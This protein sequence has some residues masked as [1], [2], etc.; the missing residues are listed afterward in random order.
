MCFSTHGAPAEMRTCSKCAG[1]FPLDGFY[2]RPQGYGN[3]HHAECKVCYR[4]R[5][6]AYKAA[7]PLRARRADRRDRE[8]LSDAYLKKMLLRMGI[9]PDQI[10]PSNIEAKRL[11]MQLRRVARQLKK[12]ANESFQDNP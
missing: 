12:A 4:A 9:P 5:V 3:T 8:S 6:R 7:H 2:K 1:V 10:T 11:Q